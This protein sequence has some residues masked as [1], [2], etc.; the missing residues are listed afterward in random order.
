MDA[1]TNV[2]DGSGA[3]LIRARLKT[4]RAAA[5]AGILFSVLLIYSLWLLRLSIPADPLETGA[6][7][8]TSAKKGILCPEPGA[9][10]RHCL[11]VVHRRSA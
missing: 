11:H 10:R 8:E 7:L 4:P 3:P 2:A 5:I 6:W 9:D 1:D